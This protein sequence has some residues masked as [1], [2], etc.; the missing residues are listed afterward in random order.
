ADAAFA[1][2]QA[3]WRE[4]GDRY[5]D[6][7]VAADRAAV[8]EAAGRLDD[9]LGALDAA[10][11]IAADTGDLERLGR[12]RLHRGQVFLPV[13]RPALGAAD[14]REAQGVFHVTGEH[15]A[16]GLAL[17][18]EGET[19]L[20]EGD[21]RGAAAALE[22]ARAIAHRLGDAALEA[23]IARALEPVRP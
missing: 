15:G 10:V 21:D 4:V 18:A 23:E 6:G 20:L 16:L 8:L 17:F 13:E 22:A 5:I 2:S 7:Q 11:A 19:A 14:Y 1:R 9:A 3:A 12:R